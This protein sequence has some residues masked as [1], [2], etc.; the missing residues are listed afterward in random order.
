VSVST[1]P[2]PNVSFSLDSWMAELGGWFQGQLIYSPTAGEAGRADGL[3]VRLRYRTD[4]RGDTDR[5]VV[6][7]QRYPLQAETASSTPFRVPVAP[8]VPISYDGE[9]IKLRWQL[10]VAA[11][12]PWRPDHVVTADVVVVPVGAFRF[13]RGPHPFRP[14]PG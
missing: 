10:E 1:S 3:R 8:N 11:T 6:V 12:R 14:V 13:Y 9:L 4:G 2:E 5:G 7:E